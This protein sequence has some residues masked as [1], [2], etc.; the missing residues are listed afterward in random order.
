MEVYAVSGSGSVFDPWTSDPAQEVAWGS[1][2]KS[3]TYTIHDGNYL[4]YQNDPA[5]QDLSRSQIMKNATKTVLNSV[6]DMNVG[7]MRFN[8]VEGGVIIRAPIDLDTNRQA[9]LD[10]VDGLG[11]DGWTPLAE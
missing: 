5:T 10:Q 7:L 8:S 11:A 4:N 3:T 9:L 6:N 1:S 2:G